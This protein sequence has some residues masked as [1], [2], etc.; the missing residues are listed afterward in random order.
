MRFE[1]G[2][3]YFQFEDPAQYPYSPATKLIQAKDNSSSGIPHVESFLV[4]TDKWTYNFEDMSDYDYN[5][6][7]DWFVNIADGMMNEF[8][9]INDLGV[10][11]VVRFTT[12]EIN[13]I[14]NDFGLW[15]G[16]F[17]VERVA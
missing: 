17:Q 6:L 12:D 2:A 11:A 3:T 5:G 9:V 13:F 1:L 14:S 10:T 7:L 4:Q 16:S 15:S 8:T